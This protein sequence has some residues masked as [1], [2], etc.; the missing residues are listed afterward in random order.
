MFTKLLR[1]LRGAAADPMERWNHDPLGSA[2]HADAA[3]YRALFERARALSYPDIDQLEASL[4]YAV[5]K[6][7]LDE[8]A[9]HT[10]VVVKQS[11]LNYQHGR[12]LYAVL[13]ECLARRDGESVH[14]LETGTARGFSSI[15]MA[16]AIRDA[17]HTG[18]I[19]TLDVLPHCKPIYWNCI[20]DCEGRK[21]REAL[22]S[23]WRELLESV[24]FLQ[25]DTRELLGRLAVARVDFAFL[26]AQHSYEAVMEEA[27]FVMARQ[28]P[29][30]VIVFDDVTEALFP[31]VVAAVEA[32]ETR[33]HYAVQRLAVTEQ[34]GY[35][36]ARCQG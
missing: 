23:P 18:V 7:W 30:D 1:R 12:V 15:C 8:L 6:A 31:G 24:V 10:Q 34:R 21:T 20:D 33:Y 2:P 26:D 25:G 19:L 11:E 28:R 13:R 17:D 35:A 29:G 14:V 16:R 3:T 36:I 9:L 32:I 27:A 4:G 22:L 5:D